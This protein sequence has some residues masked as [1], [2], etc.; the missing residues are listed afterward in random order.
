MLSATL[1]FWMSSKSLRPVVGRFRC[2]LQRRCAEICF[3]DSRHTRNWHHRCCYKKRMKH[4]SL[5]DL[6]YNEEIV[7]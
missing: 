5:Y 1:P 4:S 7:L 3:L 2:S 6:G